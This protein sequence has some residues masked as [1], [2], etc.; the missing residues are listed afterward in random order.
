MAEYGRASLLAYA[1]WMAAHESPYLDHPEQLEYPTETWAAQELWKSEVFLFA[2]KHA[3]DDER[4][5]FMERSRFFFDYA[6]R[7]LTEMPTRTLARPMMLLLSHGHMAGYFAQRADVLP[8]PATPGHEVFGAPARF[9]PQ[10]EQARNRAVALA[11]AGLALVLALA[12]Y[13][14]RMW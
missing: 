11:A 7:T 14:V 9:V 1:R 8:A 5:R 4:A 3:A 12:I 10:K 2:A 6:V 13:L